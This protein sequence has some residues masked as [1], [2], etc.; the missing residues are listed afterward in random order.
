MPVPP[1][2]YGVAI[3]GLST[4][5][6]WLAGWL[7]GTDNR[8][9]LVYRWN[10]RSWIRMLRGVDLGTVIA[11]RP[12]DVFVQLGSGRLPR[13][14]GSTWTAYPNPY[15]RGQIAAV[16]TQLWRIE[17]ATVGGRRDR[18]VI[19]RWTGSTWRTMTSPHPL[20]AGHVGA[21]FS[22]LSPLNVW[23]E[24]RNNRY[25]TAKLLHWNG[26]VWSTLKAP[27]GWLVGLPGVAAVG[28]DGVWIDDGSALWSGRK[29]QGSSSSCGS[30]TGVRRTSAALC[31]GGIQP[32]V[33]SRSYGV[34]SQNGRLP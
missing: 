10:G 17:S 22:G 20:V 29:W 15:G 27:A 21:T 4:S 30:V 3:S 28:T 19:Q 24:L 16:G 23:V 12:A 31:A 8:Q 26:R 5:D 2:L 18:L 13:W 32:G 1:H 34:I 6:V 14:N 33:G 7:S 11:I 25:Q 9:G